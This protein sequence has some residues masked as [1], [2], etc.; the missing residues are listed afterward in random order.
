M[1]K[2]SKK[3]GNEGLVQSPIP[4]ESAAIIIVISDIIVSARTL[5]IIVCISVGGIA[6]ILIAEPIIAEIHRKC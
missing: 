5:G 3:K 4:V 2:S 6:V 1:I